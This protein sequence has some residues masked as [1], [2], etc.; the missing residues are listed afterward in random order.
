VARC[1]WRRSTVRGLHPT[2]TPD[3]STG[4]SDRLPARPHPVGRTVSRPLAPRVLATAYLTSAPGS[5]PGA[6]PATPRVRRT[7]SVAPRRSG[8]APQNPVG[9]PGR[10]R[11]LPV[12]TVGCRATARREARRMGGRGHPIGAFG[13]PGGAG[14]SAGSGSGA[15]V[16]R[17]GADAP[18]QG[19]GHRVP[20]SK[21]AGRLGSPLRDDTPVRAGQPRGRRSCSTPRPFSRRRRT[22]PARTR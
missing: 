10:A 16:S 12:G 6:M 1:T 4:R 14:S 5:P 22:A 15:P 13:R 17:S 19:R 7:G 3:G 11:S 18:R 21:W 2:A 9:R 20:M 8:P